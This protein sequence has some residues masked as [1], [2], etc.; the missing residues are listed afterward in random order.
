MDLA[1]GQRPEFHVL[2]ED[3]NN[4]VEQGVFRARQYAPF[5][6]VIDIDAREVVA[7]APRLEFT[8]LSKLIVRLDR[9]ELRHDL[10]EL[11]FVALVARG[12]EVLVTDGEHPNRNR[13]DVARKRGLESPMA[14]DEVV[15]KRHDELQRLTLLGL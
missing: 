2:V 6:N 10:I 5:C 3:A 4:G 11:L 9:V 13:L 7:V 14:T 12:I 8:R 15:I 1:H